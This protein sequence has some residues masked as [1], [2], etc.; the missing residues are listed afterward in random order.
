[1][2]KKEKEKDYA[3]DISV[4]VQ[5]PATPLLKNH[6]LG[7]YWAVLTRAIMSAKHKNRLNHNIHS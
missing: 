3:G 2:G 6:I 5:I 1:M 4:G 7:E